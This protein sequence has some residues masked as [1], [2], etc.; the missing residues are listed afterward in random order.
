MQMAADATTA[1]AV[2]VGRPATGA[3]I[4]SQLRH[5]NRSFWRSPIGAFFTII[6]PLLFLVLLSALFGNETITGDVRIAQFLTPAIAAFAAT[7]A[8]FTSLA[9]GLVI[10]REQG[11][12]KRARGTPLSPWMFMVARIG[13]TIWIAVVSVALM[14]VVGV[15]FFDVQLIARTAPAAVT[16]LAVG[17][18]CFA[19]LGLAVVALVPSQSATQAITNAFIIP[20]AF[21]SDVFTPGIE[22][23]AW[24]ETIGWIFPLKHFANALGDTFNPFASGAQFGWNHLAVVAAWGIAGTVV[25]LRFFRWEPRPAA[26][27]PRAQADESAGSAPTASSALRPV[28]QQA[29]P[30]VATL[31]GNQVAYTARAYA[32]N[33]AGS[34]FV[35]VFPVILLLLLPVV[36]GNNELPFRGG[37]RTTQFLAPVLAVYGSATAAYADFSQRVA[38]A[39]DQGVLKRIH[40]TPLPVWAFMTGRIITA[41]I[42]AFAS[43]VITVGV[44]MI[45]YGVDLVPRA[46]PGLLVS[47]AVGIAC[48]A[49][50]GLAIAA[51]APN[52]EAVPMIANA[53]LLPLAFFSDIFIIDEVPRWMQIIGSFFPLKHFANA[54]ADGMNPTIAGAGF[55][56]DHL[57]VM[58]LWLVIAVVA[59]L[60]FWTWEPRERTGRRAANERRSGRRA[61]RGR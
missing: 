15:V 37:I 29:R 55:F 16:T 58:A 54:V 1:A 8:S 25:A 43:L 57:A 9:I 26:R 5:A 7:T 23:P 19:A 13:S 35:V 24:L 45:V 40:G 38:F 3:I 2:E 44:G 6:F 42:V 30:G 56:A 49:A 46:L 48:F 41:I 34:F 17:I 53:T 4:W 59:T 31:I 39:R 10:D 36:F 18:A 11:I 22:L 14:L 32:R 51:V 61:R 50:L 12:L 27:S 60:R 47:V 21:I 33:V 52:A 28:V 20:L